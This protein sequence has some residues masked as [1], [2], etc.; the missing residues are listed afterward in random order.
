[1]ELST[2]TLKRE[3]NNM[4]KS[5]G[6]FEGENDYI[7]YFWEIGLDGCFDGED[8]GIWLFNVTNEDLCK[9]PEL[10]GVKTIRLHER[11]DGFVI[12]LKPIMEEAIIL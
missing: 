5:P 2:Y 8:N 1:M 6:K 3:V 11:E 7:P 9:W 12:E 10:E 4:I